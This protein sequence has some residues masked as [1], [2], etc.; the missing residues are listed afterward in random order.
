MKER[1]DE[2]ENIIDDDNITNIFLNNIKKKRNI[3]DNQG[4]N[5]QVQTNNKSKMNESKGNFQSRNNNMNNYMSYNMN[6]INNNFNNNMNNYMNNNINNNINNNMNN[7]YNNNINNNMNNN[8]QMI[9]MNN[10]NSQNNNNMNVNMGISKNILSQRNFKINNQMNICMDFNNSMNNINISNNNM[11][12]NSNEN[13]NN[14]FNNMNNNPMNI[15][16]NQ[17]QMNNSMNKIQMNNHINLSINNIN[18]NNNM[19]NPNSARI[20]YNNNFNNINNKIYQLNL[21]NKMQINPKFN[22][23]M[24]NFNLSINQ[25]NFNNRNNSFNSIKI[26]ISN[27]LN[28]VFSQ[29]NLTNLM[30]EIDILKFF[31]QKERECIDFINKNFEG[32]DYLLNYMINQIENIFTKNPI[33]NHI[34]LLINSAIQSIP[35]AS[36]KSEK[37]YYQ[38]LRIIYGDTPIPNFLTKKDLKNLRCILFEENKNP[39]NSI[40][41]RIQNRNYSQ[42]SKKLFEFLDGFRNRKYNALEGINKKSDLFM[43]FVAINFKVFKKNYNGELFFTFLKENEILIK[44]NFCLNMSYNDLITH[45]N[46]IKNENQQNIQKDYFFQLIYNDINGN[47]Y[48]IFNIIASFYYLLLYEFKDSRQFKYVSNIGNV[49]INLILKNLVIFLDEKYKPENLNINFFYLLNDLYSFDIKYLISQKFLKFENK[50]YYFEDIDSILTNDENLSE[51]YENL[52]RSF[53]YTKNQNVG[54]MTLLKEKIYKFDPSIE[55]EK[56]I[57]LIPLDANIFSNTITIII[58]GFTTQTQN[59]IKEWKDLVNSFQNETMFY[60][61]KWPTDSF[62]NIFDK[63]ILN[64]LMNISKNFYSATARAKICGKLLALILLSSKFFKNFQ[65]NLIGFSLG[66]H[67]IKHCLKELYKYNNINKK[68]FIKLKNVILIAGATHISG[69]KLWK[70]YIENYI[71]DRFINCYSR[72]D[73]VLSLAYAKCMSK[74]AVGSEELIIKDD[75]GN[76]M[77]KNYDF[78]LDNFGHTSYKYEILIKRLFPNYKDI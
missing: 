65:I 13:I 47:L 51:G 10:Y 29:D 52:K 32:D 35:L 25:N 66:N 28:E 31:S 73:E 23:M 53:S 24:N 30:N 20:N 43:L 5:E 62:K 67:V 72:V 64:G 18:M 42:E 26:I 70:Q 6:N 54:V 1:I 16:A 19:G 46:E 77:V 22:N 12:L 78:T 2:K 75:N 14:C 39:T 59:Q 7:N 68:N 37:E 63:G 4:I 33:I 76:N 8:N 17:N 49:Y 58:D 38:Q 71:I 21:N 61:Y 69:N 56:S 11:N 34:T 60:F 27:K 41:E 36:L 44:Q 55:Y 48:K 50:A 9:N 57:E 15:S 3:H 40:I 74:K 45:F